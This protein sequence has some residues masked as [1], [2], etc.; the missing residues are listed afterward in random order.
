MSYEKKERKNRKRM[1]G[2]SINNCYIVQTSFMRT[3]ILY[4]LC[5]MYFVCIQSCFC[6]PVLCV[7]CFRIVLVLNGFQEA[8]ISILEPQGAQKASMY[9]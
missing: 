2:E 9:I 3:F 4:G 5:I 8:E 6:M 1:L 7:S